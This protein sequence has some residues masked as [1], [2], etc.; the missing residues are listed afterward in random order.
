MTVSSKTGKKTHLKHLPFQ[1]N[2]P[3]IYIYLKFSIKYLL[4]VRLVASFSNSHIFAILKILL[5]GHFLLALIRL[6]RIFV[7]GLNLST[8]FKSLVFAAVL[9]MHMHCK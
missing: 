6:L 9:F 1:S 3:R 8:P 2:R 7:H 4:L 5:R